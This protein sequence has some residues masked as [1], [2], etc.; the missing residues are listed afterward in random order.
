MGRSVTHFGARTVANT[1]AKVLALI[2]LFPG[3]HIDRLKLDAYATALTDEDITN[4]IHMHWVGITI[5]WQYLDQMDAI[6]DGTQADFSTV[7]QYDAAFDQLVMSANEGT[8]ELLGGDTILDPEE[9][10]EDDDNPS[11]DP[12][13]IDDP[14]GVVKF[15]THKV[16]GRPYAAAGNNTIRFGD[17]FRMTISGKRIPIQKWGSLLMLGMIR[18]DMSQVQADFA[19]ELD[20]VAK[21]RAIGLLKA[22]VIN[23]VAAQIATD[24]GTVGDTIRTILFGGD[25]FIEASTIKAVSVKAYMTIEAHISGP[26]SR[27]MGR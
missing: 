26:L 15:L 4:P 27:N 22:G 21:I 17:D 13:L 9:T 20:S 7:A 19:M 24:S 8:S 12:L 16:I 11:E 25:N 5:P 14:M 1:D 3:E 6:A 23:R 18:W 10:I 2:P